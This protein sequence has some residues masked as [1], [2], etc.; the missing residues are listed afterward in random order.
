MLITL[1][2][3]MLPKIAKSA[4]AKMDGKKTITGIVLTGA[5]IGMLFLPGFQDDG[6]IAIAS[7][8]PIL[9]TGIWHKIQKRKKAK[10]ERTQKKE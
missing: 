2:K 7:G 3:I 10:A 1:L 9:A 4:A 6:I 5:G 8:T